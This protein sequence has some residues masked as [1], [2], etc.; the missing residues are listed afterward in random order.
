MKI[1]HHRLCGLSVFFLLGMFGV[2]QKPVIRWHTITS[3]AT[4]EPFTLV[5][6]TDTHLGQGLPDRDYGSPGFMDSLNEK[7]GGYAAERLRNAVQNINRLVAGKGACLVILSGDIT[8]S[9]ERS[10]FLHALRMLRELKAP[11]VPLIGNHDVWPYA[12][13]GDEAPSAF[14]DSLMNH[15]FEEQF[16]RLKELFRFH[17]EQRFFPCFDS[18]SGQAV[19]LQ[20]FSFSF[21]DWRF[22]FLDFNPRYHVRANEPGIGPEVYLHPQSC[23]TLAFLRRQIAEAA[24]AQEPVCLISHHPPLT[25]KIFGKHYAF[26]R[27]QKKELLDILR[28]HR[29]IPRIWLCGH[30]HRNARYGL[31]GTGPLR[32]YE[33]KANMRASGGAFRLFRMGT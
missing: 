26:T 23:G 12:G 15:L 6:I 4:K 16:K 24:C 9:G 5:H 19:Y 27:Q 25:V 22:V 17:E 30:F 21:H 28:S 14:G 13:L 18:L 29:G 8:D 10:E 1:F 2:A 32:V 31:R 33:T 11:W 7:Q 3:A 20:N